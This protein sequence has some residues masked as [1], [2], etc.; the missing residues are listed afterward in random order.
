MMPEKPGGDG[1]VRTPGLAEFFQAF[2]R[3]AL[4][5]L[6]HLLHRRGQSQITDRPDIGTTQRAQ[7]ID[8]RGPVSDAFKGDE[9][10]AR[11]IVVQFVEVTEIEVTPGKRLG[12]E[13]GV[14]SFLAAEA[15]AKQLDVGQFQKAARRERVNG[16]VKTIES[17]FRGS[18]RNLLLENDVDERGEARFTDP[19]R[20]LAVLFHDFSEMGIAIREKTHTLCEE[21]FIQDGL[22]GL[23]GKTPF[24]P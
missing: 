24:D 3:R 18:E 8:V 13:T 9:H 7:Q 4:A 5:E 15:D 19:E 1:A 6:L 17:G 22:R 23:Q 10:F 11:G 2:W 14:E 21:I 12:E 20:R 16:G